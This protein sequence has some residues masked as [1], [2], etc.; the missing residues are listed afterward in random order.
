MMVIKC[1]VVSVELSD[2]E[3]CML[4]KLFPK[5]SLSEALNLLIREKC[6]QNISQE[7]NAS[8]GRSGS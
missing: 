2:V 7:A 3:V 1:D 5:V 4:Q 8:K 6:S